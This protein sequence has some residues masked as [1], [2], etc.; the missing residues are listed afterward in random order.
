MLKANRHELKIINEDHPSKS[1]GL[2]IRTR[3]REKTPGGL[4]KTLYDLMDTY[5]RDAKARKAYAS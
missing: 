2:S 4:A 5:I 1:R 3:L